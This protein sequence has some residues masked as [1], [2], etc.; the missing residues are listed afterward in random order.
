[1]DSYNILLNK[2]IKLTNSK[3]ITLNKIGKKPKGLSKIYYIDNVLSN[4]ENFVITDKADGIRSF[5]D[6]YNNK[7]YILS[8]K[9]FELSIKKCNIENCI[10][11]CEIINELKLILIY[12][13]IFFNNKILINEEFNKRKEYLNKL[14]INIDNWEVKLKNFIPLTIATYQ[15]NILK[16]YND[17]K[18]YKYETDGIIFTNIKK[19]YNNA[20]HY[21]WKPPDKLTIDFLI[22]WDKKTNELKLFSGINRRMF[23]RFGLKFKEN[24][25]ELTYKYNNFKNNILLSEFFPIPFQPSINP[26]IYKINYK[27]KS[28]D[29]KLYD[30]KLLDGKIVELSWKSNQWIIYRIRTDR[31][32]ELE[33]KTYYGNNFYIAENTYYE[34]I[35]PFTLNDLLKPYTEL[36]KSIYFSKNDLKYKSVRKFNN[37]VKDLLIARYSNS[38]YIIDIG[39]GKGQDIKKYSDA[40]IS[41][42]L[43]LEIDKD[44]IYELISKKNI[45]LEKVWIDNIDYSIDIINYEPNFQLY[46]SE[47]DLNQPIN[48]NIKKLN[49]FTNYKEKNIDAIICNFALHYLVDTSKHLS[50]IIKFID[51]WLKPGGIFIFTAFDK[52]SINL[53]LKDKLE[54][55][56]K[57]NNNEIIYSI[58]KK[59][60][61][62]IDVLI[63]CS[64]LPK[65]EVLINLSKLDIEF[66]KVNIY[67][68][69]TDSFSKFLNSDDLLKNLDLSK[70]DKT[71]IS[72]YSYVIWQKK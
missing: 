52:N 63:P 71:F 9:Y 51:Y 14:E 22:L 36:V 62:K 29:N 68:I 41:N 7:A 18:K 19:N 8:D 2:I 32:F 12:D 6:I 30:Y 5:I 60:N 3:G 59:I 11:E 28:I 33:S 26:E 72:L 48:I 45:I 53:L 15:N 65:E 17:I 10:I 1:M 39:S 37:R 24:Y 56:I 21:K 61:N 4:I 67:R 44:A 16:L 23:K 57:D 66:K 40:H 43:M 64:N 49:I 55:V 58:K 31:D 42:L 13:I 54:W 69:E 27:L 47:M 35:H 34:C 25:K 50:N 38:D 70:D 46:I 20:E